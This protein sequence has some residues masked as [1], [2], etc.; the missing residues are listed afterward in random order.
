MRRS[1]PSF[2][3][4]RSEPAK[5]AS[6]DSTRPLRASKPRI[7]SDVTLFPHPDSPTIP[8]VSPRAMSNEMPFTACTVP[9]RVQK[10]TCRS[11][12]ESRGGLAT[13]AQLRVERLAQAVTDQVE[14]EDGDDD[15]EPRDD[16]EMWGALQVP[17]DVREHR[18]PLR[19]GGV[20]R[21]EPEETEAGNIDDR[22][23]ECECAL[24]DHRREGIWEDV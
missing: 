24:D 1:P 12:T 6:P 17:I 11:S 15:R 23:C 5:R 3:R 13:P 8:S 7:A 20:L 14:P 4:I 16:R 2:W 19:G 22:R 21:S 18:P 10:R 9:R